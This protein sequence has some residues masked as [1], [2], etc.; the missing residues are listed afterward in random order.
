MQSGARGQVDNDG[1]AAGRILAWRQAPASGEPDVVLGAAD[2]QR[3]VRQLRA[4]LRRE[5]IRG[6]MGHWTYDL[7]RHLS[8]ARQ[9][10]RAEAML[11]TAPAASKAAEGSVTDPGRPTDT[12]P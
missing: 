1:P 9:L 8:L 5:R 7:T 12:R 10:R 3:F 2:A 4:A 11:T 6:R